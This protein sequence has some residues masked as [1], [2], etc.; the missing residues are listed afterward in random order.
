MEWAHST[1]GVV[2]FCL[3]DIFWPVE[4]LRWATN[5]GTNDKSLIL[6]QLKVCLF[7][8]D[9]ERTTMMVGLREET[10]FEVGVFGREM[11]SPSRAKGL[12]KHGTN[13][14]RRGNA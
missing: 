5:C 4:L 11:L 14:Y 8:D 9:V 7:L 3:H 12:R 13:P 10:F 6:K 1:A 2:F